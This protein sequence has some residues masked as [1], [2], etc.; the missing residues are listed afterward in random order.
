MPFLRYHGVGS[1]FREGKLMEADEPIPM[2]LRAHLHLGE[3]RARGMGFRVCII[4]KEANVPLSSE[5][6]PL[7]TNINTTLL[8]AMVGGICPSHPAEANSCFCNLSPGM[9]PYMLFTI[10]AII[11]SLC[12]AKSV[13][14]SSVTILILRSQ[15]KYTLGRPTIMCT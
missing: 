11:L 4:T 14:T 12:S 15:G 9:P 7:T 2:R 10:R 5:S 3:E 1:S 8:Q 13:C 6:E